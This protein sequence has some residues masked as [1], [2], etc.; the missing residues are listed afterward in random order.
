MIRFLLGIVV[1]IVAT[2]YVLHTE[3]GEYLLSPGTKVRHLE[4]QLQHADEQQNNLVKKLEGATAVI[5]KMATQFTALEQ[6]FQALTPQARPKTDTPPV[7]EAPTAP[8]PEPGSVPDSGTTLEPP[9]T[10]PTPEASGANN[11]SDSSALQ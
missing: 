10:P 6:R 4:E 5:E 1:G 11:P 3:S 9:G 2:I 8:A 7:A